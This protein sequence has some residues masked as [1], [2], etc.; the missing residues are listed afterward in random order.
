MIWTELHGRLMAE[1]FEHILRPEQGAM[2]F[3]RCLPPEVV[4][5]LAGDR[6]GFAP[7]DW[8]VRRIADVEDADRRTIPADQ[9]VELREG[10]PQPILFL[11]DTSLAGAGTD[12]V[13]SATREIHEATLFKE[14][15]KLALQTITRRLSAK[16]RRYA[17]RA[18]KKAQGHGRRNCVSPWQAFDF[19][20]RVAAEQRHPGSLLHLLGLW[21]EDGTLEDGLD[22]SCLFVDRLVGPAVAARTP[23][24]RIAALKLAD[25]SDAQLGDLERFLRIAATKPLLTAMAELADKPPLWVGSLRLET[26]GPQLRRIGLESWRNP[27]SGKIAAWTGLKEADNA[28]EP[29]RLVLDPKA[30]ETANYSKLEI[31][32]KAEP[33]NLK[34]GAVEYRVAIV[35]DM[36]EEL[37][38]RE[39]PHAGKTVEK[40]RFSDDD[41][42]L[43]N[44][45]ALI[46]AKAIVSVLG[47]EGVEAQETEEFKILFGLVKERESPGVGK[48]VRTASEGFIELDDREQVTASST[49]DEALTIDSRNYVLVRT[50]ERSKAYRVYC[51]PL[52]HEVTRDWAAQVDAIG[53]W[54]VR[55]RASGDRTGAPE[56]VSLD[57]PTEAARRNVWDRAVAA[58]R[59]ISKRFVDFGGVGHVYDD[60]S[61]IY[62][63]VKEYLLAWA[64]LLEDADPVL[65]L[66]NTVEIQSL[67]GRTIGLIVLPSHPLRVAWHI[68]YDNLVLH[69]K[70][71]EGKTAKE[72]REEFKVLDGAMFPAFL[73]GLQPGS[74]FAF[75]DT[76][77]FHAVGMIPDSDKEPKAAVAILVRA[78][79]ESESLDSVPTVGRQ[80]AHVLG[81]EI[82]KYLECHDT[83]RFLRIHALRAGDGLTVAR[84]LGRVQQRYERS[85]DDEQDDEQEAKTPA[86]VLEL[87][88]SPEQQGIAGRFIAETREKRRSGAGT[89][90]EDDRWMLESLSLPGGINV[91]RLRWARKETEPKTAAHLAVAF[92]TFESR[93]VADEQAA[94]G[95]TG[96]FIAFGMLSFFA[97]Q[98]ASL[99]APV[100]RSLVPDPTNGEKHPS[101]R[102]HTERLVR[103]QQ[104]VQR[105][106]AR[107]LNSEASRCVLKTEISPEKAHS[108]RELHR[109]C[110]WVITLDRNAG[111]EYFDSPRDNREIYDAY[112][113]DCV[114]EREDLGCLQLIT[115]TSN[116]DEVRK[117]LDAALDQMGL[118]H[119]RRNAEFLMEHLKALSGR[120]AIRLTGQRAP[121]SELIALAMSHANC[122]DAEED[123][124]CW[125]TLRRGFL[126]PVDDVRDLL[127]PLSAA[128]GQDQEAGTRP[129]LIYVSMT[130]R[131]GLTF[132]FVEVK[133]R[134]HLRTARSPETL[135]TIR[136]Q[137]E[138]LRGRWADWYSKDVCP[139]FRAIRRA[140]LARVLHFYA[141]KARR[142]A[143]DERQQGLSADAHAA[144]TAEIDRMLEKGGDYSFAQVDRPDLGWVFCP[145]YAGTSPLEISPGDWDTRVFLFGPRLMPDTPLRQDPVQLGDGAAPGRTVSG[146]E[147]RAVTPE[148]A[149]DGNAPDDRLATQSSQADAAPAGQTDADGPPPVESQQAVEPSVCLGTDLLSG[150]EVRWALT[151]RGNPHL[152]IA[153]LPGMGKTTCLTNLCRQMMESGIRPILFSYHED[154]DQR[155]GT[156]LPSLQFVDFSGLGF[157][158]LEVVDRQSRMSYLDVAGALRDIFVAIFPELGDIQGES[159]RNAI[160]QSFI[161]KGWDDPQG[162]L[163]DLQEPE[164]R[165]FLE[166]LRAIPKPDRGLRSLLGRLDELADYGFFNLAESCGSLWDSDQPLV[167]RIHRT[168]NDNLQKAFASL[169]FYKLYKDMFRRGIQQRVTHAVIFDEAH[170]AARLT[171]IPTMAKEC[172][173]YGISLVLASQEARDFHVSLFSAIANYLV[174]RVTEADAKALVRN[175]ASSDQERAL[176]D[177]IKQMERFKALYFCEQRKKPSFVALRP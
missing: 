107:H 173:K 34:K 48:K 149:A 22:L 50:K 6:Q 138:S 37:A 38:S 24:Q 12:S 47:N 69:G 44:E 16:Q 129:D 114:P 147:S 86:F 132:R 4:E 176:I 28:D 174:L 39:L 17:D 1:A 51:P 81:D 113:I 133:Y 177:K 121:T 145:E 171:L 150:A 117:L 99:P 62:E 126:I 97:R 91:P 20:V 101:D 153:G 168:Q 9:A 8:L 119:S 108:L 156:L 79:G 102:F 3:V 49:P 76:L 158:P 151:L 68:A 93:V 109:L 172:R 96:P 64:A 32:W 41:F 90:A 11:V 157:N 160:K 131:R 67:S 127:R 7:K 123:T 159:I 100:W 57:A 35:S 77:G 166:I 143:D 140:K 46:S 161:E 29:P 40:C 61:P 106:V 112:V 165:R 135:K 128:E 18:V 95:T 60:K 148:A 72:I 5:A 118:S 78:L 105:C 55:V 162:S 63:T 71:V 73:P 122:W 92:D 30:A 169:V 36:D 164:F 42:S 25:P 103:V 170:R 152:L 59:N 120:L 66:A 104:A 141:D 124:D 31:R 154:I 82:R 134:R 13:Y 75:A 15:S 45:D 111:I 110:D 14:A 167:I 58:S 43:L 155:L 130:A 33:A 137:V 65:A 116:I 83:S 98:Y 125:T 52:I 54:R 144:V 70:F 84:S 27:K 10:P 19:F 146:D 115:S 85:A 89:V 23:A 56:F 142:H 139:S 26:V 136:R 163:N 74:A 88:P 53:R 87:Y 80:S 94:G 2:A 175:V 21:P